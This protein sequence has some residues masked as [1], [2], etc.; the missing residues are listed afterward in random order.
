MVFPTGE[1]VFGDSGGDHEPFLVP[2]AIPAI[3]GPSALATVMLMASRDPAHLWT[4]VLAVSIGMA[5]TTAVLVAAPRLQ[6]VLGE[7]AVVALE[8]LMGLVLTAVAVQMLLNGVQA[9]VAEL[10]K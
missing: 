4:W 5:V 8:R 2:L 9:F 6:A 7:R 1:G 3:A 10:P